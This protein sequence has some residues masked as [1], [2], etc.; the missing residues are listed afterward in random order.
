MSDLDQP[1]SSDTICSRFHKVA[2]QQNRRGPLHILGL[3]WPSY[4]SGIGLSGPNKTSAVYQLYP[5]VLR[6]SQPTPVAFQAAEN[7]YEILMVCH[8]I[9]MPSLRYSCHSGRETSEEVRKWG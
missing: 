4:A 6:A 3:F 1:P 7:L 5:E 9:F 8:A 2:Q